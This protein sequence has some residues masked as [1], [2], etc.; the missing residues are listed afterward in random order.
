MGLPS[1]SRR[2]TMTILAASLF[3]LTG[4]AQAGPECTC[5]FAGQSFQLKSC[6]CITTSAGPRIAC[7]GMVLNNTSWT[8][9]QKAC[10]LAG[11]SEKPLA[12]MEFAQ[13]VVPGESILGQKEFALR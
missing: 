1:L 3:V 8:F 2:L 6:A 13:S 10:P 11:L 12:P 5:R 7:C 9:T 4:T